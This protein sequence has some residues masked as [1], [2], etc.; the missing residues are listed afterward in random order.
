MLPGFIKVIMPIE[1]NCTVYSFVNAGRLRSNYWN[2]KK[3]PFK[4]LYATLDQVYL[5]IPKQCIL[6]NVFRSLYCHNFSN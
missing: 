6:V 5:G 4:I 3:N 2:V 1:T